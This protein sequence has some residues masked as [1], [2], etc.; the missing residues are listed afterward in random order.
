MYILKTEAS[1]LIQHIFFLD[2]MENVVI[3]MD[4]DGELFFRSADR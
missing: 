4:T 2:M 1:F 3:F